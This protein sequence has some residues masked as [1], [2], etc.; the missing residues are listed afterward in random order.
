MNKCDCDKQI[1]RLSILL[2]FHPGTMRAD[3]LQNLLFTGCRL[4]EAARVSSIQEPAVDIDRSLVGP[5]T[6][7]SLNERGFLKSLHPALR[8]LAALVIVLVMPQLAGKI[9][10]LLAPPPRI[11]SIDP[12]NAYAWLSVHHLIQIVLTLGLMAAWA[13]G[14]LAQWGFNLRELKTSLR[15]LGWF[16]LFFTVGTLVFGILPRVLAHDVQAKFPFGPFPL[17]TRNVAGSLGFYYLLSGSGE[18]PLFRGFIM[19]MLLV[20]WKKE[21]RLGKIVMPAAGILATL[22]FMLAHVGYELSP[23]RITQFTWQ[24][25]LFCLGLGL[26][27][28]A[29][30]YRTG[31]LVCPILA[32]GFSNG[33]VWSLIYGAM[34]LT[35]VR[36]ISP[37]VLGRVAVEPNPPVAGQELTIR[38]EAKGGALNGSTQLTLQYG[39]NGWAGATGQPMTNSGAEHWQTKLVLP[40]RIGELDFAFTDGTRWDNNSGRDWRLP[41]KAAGAVR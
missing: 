27:Y 28:A 36:P 30:I 18:E 40:P 8:L 39:V 11:H 17:N 38:Y 29:A 31:S 33:I 13:R 41:A 6:N 9:G 1:V 34:V 7:P 25:Q 24:Q 12:D 10:A 2:A 35:P 5:Q 21:W 4:L 16:V 15:W 22:L 14:S 20:G 19:S 3:R 37:Q 32:H 23:F 26:F